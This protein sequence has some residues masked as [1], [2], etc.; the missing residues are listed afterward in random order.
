MST[1][2]LTLIDVRHIQG[3]LFNANELRQNIGASLLVEQ[4]THEWVIDHLPPYNNIEWLPHEYRHKFKPKTIEKDGLEAEV[5]FMGGANVAILFS[6]PDLAKKFAREYTTKVLLDAPGM[7][8]AVGCTE[9]PWEADG[10]RRAWQRLTGEIMPQRK[11]GRAVSQPLAGLAVTAECAYTGQP[12]AEDMPA[13]PGSGQRV[14]VSAE[15][16]VKRHDTTVNQAKERLNALL[17]PGKEAFEYPSRFEDLGGEAGRS[18]YIAV[19]HADGNRMGKRIENYATDSD[20]REMIKKMREFSE[21]LNNIGIEAMR[22][23]CDW[24]RAAPGGFSSEEQAYFIPDRWNESSGIWLQGSFLPIRPLVYGG[25]DVTFVCDGRLGL[26][27]AEKFL[28]AF[29]QFELPDKETAYACAGVAIVHSNYPFARAYALAEKLSKDA[30]GQAERYDPKKKVSLLNW[31]IS[32]SGLA[33]N[34]DVI[35]Q[36]EFTS[37]KKGDLL[38]R[39]L[40]VIKDQDVSD[41]ETAWR[42]WPVFLKQVEE[43]RC[44]DRWRGRRNKVKELRAA[45]R[46]GEAAGE[47]FTRLHGALPEVVLGQDAHKTGWYSKRCVYFDALEADDF[48]INPVER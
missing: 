48:F 34:W 46:K 8:V 21:S 30:K 35:Q 28:R 4:A 6:S 37:S 18:S 12:A 5:I 24:L 11:E 33:L 13:Y 41:P 40:V 10:L 26:A 19:V 45:L 25:D 27:L 44:R 39:P 16:Q 38:L 20:N 31:H 22:A 7:E 36:R 3:Y 43:F 29:G 32:T 47:D 14:L 9:V 23:V 2:A 42:S 15:V 17:P 1:Y